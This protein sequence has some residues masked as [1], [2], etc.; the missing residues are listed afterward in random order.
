M[1]RETPKIFFIDSL[2]LFY[3]LS[4]RPTVCVTRKWAG[5]ENA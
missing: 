5:V 1:M 2:F 3:P 4:Q